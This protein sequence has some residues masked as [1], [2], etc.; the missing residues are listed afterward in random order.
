MV[1]TV[2][3]L[4]A[5]RDW[6][7]SQIGTAPDKIAIGEGGRIVDNFNSYPDDASLQAAWLTNEST[8]TRETTTPKEGAVTCKWTINASPATDPYMTHSLASEDWTQFERIAFWFK[9]PDATKKHYINIS[10][11]GTWQTA[12]DFSAFLYSNTWIYVEILFTDAGWSVDSVD[13]IRF[14]LDATEWP[15]SAVLYVDAIEVFAAD[16][17]PTDSTIPEELTRISF[18]EVPDTSTSQEV[19]FRAFLPSTDVATDGH[20]L[21]RM[22]LIND[23]N[24]TLFTHRKHADIY[25]TNAIEVSYEIQIRFQEVE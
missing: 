20:T 3:G 4:N 7:A 9:T 14:S 5:I 13:E 17:Q 12:Y 2:D 6:F 16:P 10:N 1:V 25:K 22:G 15:D 23:A 21:R 24:N 11:N 18:S 8:V 19:T